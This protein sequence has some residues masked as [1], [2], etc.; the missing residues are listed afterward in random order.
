MEELQKAGGFLENAEF[1]GLLHSVGRQLALMEFNT[2]VGC[3]RIQ[4]VLRASA[5]F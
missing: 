4:G 2:P 1:S 3:V 5:E